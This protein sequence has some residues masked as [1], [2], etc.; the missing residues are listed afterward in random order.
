MLQRLGRTKLL[1]IAGAAILAVALATV[2]VGLFVFRTIYGAP[3]PDRNAPLGPLDDLTVSENI[4]YIPDAETNP[5]QQLD[6]YA[7]QLAERETR[8]VIVFFHGGAWVGGSRQQFRWMGAGLARQG[9]VAV[10]PN[11]RLY[12]EVKWPE[13]V[14][15]SASAVRWVKDNIADYGGDPDQLVLM[16]HSSGAFNVLSLAV[17]PQWLAAE[18][19]DPVRDIK[20]VI[21]LSGVYNMLPLTGDN[22]N[23][24]FANGY[25]EMINNVTGNSPPVLFPVSP[26]DWIAKSSDPE[27]MAAKITAQGGIAEVISYPGLDHSGTVTAMG[28]AFDAP[29]IPIQQDVARFLKE[30]GVTVPSRPAAASTGGEAAPQS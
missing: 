3:Q 14:R 16:G 19:M 10:V 18:G 4:A 17:E 21:G 1:M 2:L 9:Y 15:D 20:A 22:E 30:H 8:P 13:F 6:I 29:D 26:A 11:Y 5:R 25:V 7:P 23:A 28:D 24:I 12:P 27:M